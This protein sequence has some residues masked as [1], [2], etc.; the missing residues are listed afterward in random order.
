MFKLGKFLII[1]SKHRKESYTPFYGKD[2]RTEEGARKYLCRT[3]LNRVY[4][5]D[6][7]LQ[8]ILLNVQTNRV[9]L[10]ESLVKEIGERIDELKLAH[11]EL[12]KEV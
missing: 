5:I 9:P 3:K 11:D 4:D 10:S 7:K 8:L 6:C 1:Q 12:R 2:I